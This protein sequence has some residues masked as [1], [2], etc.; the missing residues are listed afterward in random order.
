MSSSNSSSLSCSDE[1]LDE[2]YR[3][4]LQV[5]EVLGYQFQPKRD[6]VSDGSGSSSEGDQ[7]MSTDE[8]QQAV[9]HT[10]PYYP[11]HFK[12]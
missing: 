6:S 1:S 5:G 11:P 8:D 2:F 3:D 9:Q 10:K 12:L 7:N 4:M